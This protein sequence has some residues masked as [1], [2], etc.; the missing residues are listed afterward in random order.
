[1]SWNDHLQV[2]EAAAL[3]STSEGTDGGDEVRSDEESRP[4]ATR[5]VREVTLAAWSS[6]LGARAGE[7]P[8]LVIWAAVVTAAFSLL[9][10]TAGGNALLFDNLQELTA[11]GGGAIALFLAARRAQVLDRCQLRNVQLAIAIALGSACLGMTAWDL[12]HWFG[13]ALATAG[14]VIFVAGVSVGAVGVC[15]AVF[16]GIQRDRLLGVVIDTLIVFLAG[17][18]LVAA[19]WR[20][21][22]VAPGD[23]IASLGAVIL[24]AA[25]AALSVGLF[26]RRISPRTPGPWLSVAGAAV[27]GT[28][29]LMWIGNPSAP[30][31]VDLSDFMFSAGMLLIAFGGAIWEI[32]PSVNP[33]FERIAVAFNSALPVGAIVGSL[34]L[35]AISRGPDFADLLGGATSAVIVTAAIRQ[36]HLYARESRAREAV[37]QRTAE[38]Q[39]AMAALEQEIAERR[40]LEAEQEAMAERMGENQRLESIGR[41]AGGVAHDFNNLLMAIRGYTDLAASQV[42]DYPEVKADLEA[43]RHAS[44]QAASLTSQLLAFSR[45]QQLRPSVVDLSGI[46]LKTQPLLRRLLGEHVELVME[47]APSL[48][49]VMVDPSQFESII[50]N[51][52]LNARDAMG[53][54]GRLTIRMANV[55]LDAEYGRTHADVQPG[56]YAMVS[57]TDTGS[58]MDSAT[59]ARIFEPFF[60]TKAPGKGTGL[61]LSTVYGT[62][63]QSGG[64]IVV[65]SAPGRGATFSIYLPRTERPEDRPAALSPEPARRAAR[66]TIVVAE[67]ED[68]V[69]KVIVSTLRHLGYTVRAFPSGEAAIRDIE[70][71]P[72]DVGLLLTDVVMAGIDGV[73]LVQRARALHPRLPA[74]CMSGYTPPNLARE[75]GS[76]HVSFLAKPFN[77]EQLEETVRQALG[78]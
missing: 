6:R 37:S 32:R 8:G 47:P 64:H 28:A 1:M 4:A 29:W 16:G 54:A 12:S 68:S 42:G 59:Q 66:E 18:A 52:V 15:A 53:S 44:D 58:G 43:I 30:S 5:N 14:N 72:D 51:L 70:R 31:S 48:W 7:G 24:L 74:I 33:A 67:D 34:A 57:V 23:R 75:V 45:N 9:A 63:R 50:V 78:D 71:N 10:L 41:L 61:G 11:S 25:T 76:D 20:A 56:D 35:L 60:T 22:V 40:R 62:V 65:E 2:D 27:L 77:L 69:R 49:P 17:I 38:V 26:D 19:L 55:S 21:D 13:T 3:E 36:L 39:S 46:V 73:E